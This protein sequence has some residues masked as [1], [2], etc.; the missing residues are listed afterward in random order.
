MFIRLPCQLSYVPCSTRRLHLA[1]W[2]YVYPVLAS[3]IVQ[4]D[5]DQC[6]T[7]ADGRPLGS[8]HA[9][10]LNSCWMVG[11]IP[12]IVAELPPCVLMFCRSVSFAAR[13]IR[14]VFFALRCA[15]ASLFFLFA[16]KGV[17]AALRCCECF[18]C[19]RCTHK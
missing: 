14:C 18:S 6:Y 7:T 16:P 2:R 8:L 11:P 12:C 9:T 1:T 15:G 5:A 13:P 17:S 4:L 3:S 10:N 19:V